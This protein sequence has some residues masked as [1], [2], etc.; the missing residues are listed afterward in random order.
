MKIGKRSDVWVII[1]SKVVVIFIAPRIN[2]FKS[3]DSLYKLTVLK[4]K[5]N[6]KLCYFFQEQLYHCSCNCSVTI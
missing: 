3:V 1:I 6:S 4:I 5:D 2:D